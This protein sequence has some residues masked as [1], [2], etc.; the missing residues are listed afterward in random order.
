MFLQN[1]NEEILI[2][3]INFEFFH[4]L[5]N[6]EKMLVISHMCNRNSISIL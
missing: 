1:L 3:L 5:K 6:L 2:F 4:I